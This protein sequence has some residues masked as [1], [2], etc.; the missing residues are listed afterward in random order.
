MKKSSY[1]MN[2]YELKKDLSMEAGLG[3]PV[4][5]AGILFWLSVGISSFMFYLD[6]S[7]LFSPKRLK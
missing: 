4:F 7:P 5:L 1:E 2:L 6:D 3:Y